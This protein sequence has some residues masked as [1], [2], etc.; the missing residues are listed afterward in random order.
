M[1][2]KLVR[3]MQR[4][5]VALSCCPD[6]IVFNELLLLADHIFQI[7]NGPSLELQVQEQLDVLTLKEVVLNNQLEEVFVILQFYARSVDRL[8]DFSDLLVILVQILLH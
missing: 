7:D 5:T 1:S 4:L 2:I 6:I 3:L 8:F